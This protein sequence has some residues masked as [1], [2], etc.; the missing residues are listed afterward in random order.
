MA[1]TGAPLA[2]PLSLSLVFFACGQAASDV[3]FGFVVLQNLLD[4]LMKRGTD[5]LQP[6]AQILVYGALGNAESFGRGTDCRAI[7]Y[8]VLRQ[9]NG[10][11]FD[12]R[13]HITTP[14]SALVNDMRECPGVCEEPAGG[15][16]RL[17][18]VRFYSSVPAGLS[19]ESGAPW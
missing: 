2:L 1:K 16:C 6:L 3:S 14:G 8:D 15:T 17:L 5:S 10:S 4:L 13:P 18:R 19:P 12:V 9:F 7:L 11:I